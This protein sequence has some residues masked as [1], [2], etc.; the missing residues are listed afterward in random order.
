MIEISSDIP[1]KE[2]F[3][4]KPIHLTSDWENNK[5]PFQIEFF[6]AK[7][8]LNLFFGAR[9]NSNDI[10]K[11]DYKLNDF[12]EGLWQRDVI[13]LFLSKKGKENYIE[14]NLDP[15]GA[16]WIKEF[17][18]YRQ[19]SSF[20]FELSGIKTTAEIRNDY[21]QTAISLS[22]RDLPISITNDDVELNICGIIGKNQRYY[23]AYNN[24]P[25]EKPDF[26]QRKLMKNF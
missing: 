7:S 14:V 6:I 1:L 2:L 22:L 11:F 3:Q 12:R 20:Q 19:E 24:T 4:T 26:H 9:I 5:I 13:E 15:N 23:L 18:K 8:N 17:S 25:D 16:F 21:W 10:F